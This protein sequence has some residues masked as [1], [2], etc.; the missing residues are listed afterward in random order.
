MTQLSHQLRQLLPCSGRPCC[1]QAVGPLRRRS[2]YE[3]AL[4]LA[5]SSPVS[6]PKPPVGC[7]AFKWLDFGGNV[8]GISSWPAIHP[9]SPIACPTFPCRP[10]CI[11][12]APLQQY[13]FCAKT[14][15]ATDPVFP[16]WLPSPPSAGR[17]ASKW[18]DFGGGGVGGSSWLE[19]R[20]LQSQQPAVVVAY[21]LCSANDSPER[22]PCAWVLEGLVEE[23]GAA[24]AGAETFERFGASCMCL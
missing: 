4:L 7:I 24:A 8:V 6:Y 14:C 12:V 22:D 18:L 5:L 3:P 13:R 1:I 9:S 11:Q 10:R 20:L 23:A 17:V 2:W 16:P 21:D 19:Y 15:P